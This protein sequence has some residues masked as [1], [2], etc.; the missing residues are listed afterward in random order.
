MIDINLFR[1]NP[2]LIKENLKKRRDEEKLLWV[3]EIVT[4]DKEWRRL[5]VEAEKLRQRRNEVTQE[6]ND[7]RKQKQDFS[8]KVKEAKDI[9]EQIKQAEVKQEEIRQRLDFLLMRFPNILHESVPYG[10]DSSGNEVVKTHGKTFKHDFEAKS[11]VDLLT[12][13]D[14][15]DLERAAKISGA[16]FYFLKNELVLLEFAISK[17]AMD[18]MFKKGY[19]VMETPLMVS[20]KAMEGVTD[21]VAFEEMLYKIEGEDLYL[22]ATSEHAMG[23]MYMDEVIEGKDLPIKLSGYTPCFRKEAGAHGKDQKGIFRVHHFNKIEQF[24]FCKPEDSWKYHEELIKN[25][26]EFFKLLELPY[27]VVNICTG[28]IGSVAAKKYDLEIWMAVQQTYREAVSCSNCTDYQSRRLNIKWTDGSKRE[29][30]HTLNS[31]LVATSRVLVA[32]LENFQREDGSI[33]IPKALW[34]ITGFKTIGPNEK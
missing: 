11:H 17:L 19:T 3:D 25:A 31:T 18:F 20:K 13:L 4:K 22:V 33:D 28:D 21:M 14:L 24:I 5:K 1:E 6:I 10:P 7:L 9:P 34:P 27:Q 23:A 12:S 15:A 32:I 30:L 8:G 26:E 2:D 29:Y 16:R